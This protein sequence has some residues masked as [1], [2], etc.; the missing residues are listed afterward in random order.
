MVDIVLKKDGEI[1]GEHIDKLLAVL[2]VDIQHVG[3]VLIRLDELRS[4]I[5]KRDEES[6][7]ELLESIQKESNEYSANEKSR[8]KL[9]EE[10][11]LWC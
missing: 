5:V 11:R 6:L 4:L 7:G 1:V 8:Q 2:D 3:E 9:R 10:L